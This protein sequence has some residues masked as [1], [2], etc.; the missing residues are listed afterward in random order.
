M[1]DPQFATEY[2]VAMEELQYEIAKSGMV[3]DEQSD[4]TD[5]RQESG[6][7]ALRDHP[8]GGAF[9]RRLNEDLVLEVHVLYPSFT[10]DWDK[11][12]LN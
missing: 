11:N 12:D 9:V 2:D 8:L 10:S 5:E 7:R 6:W 3:F 4:P 1:E